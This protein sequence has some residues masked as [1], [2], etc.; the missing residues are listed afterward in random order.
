[1]GRPRQRVRASVR[2][3]EAGI[4]AP[5]RPRER[6]NC[7]RFHR[8]AG[9]DPFTRRGVHRDRPCMPAF[10]THAHDRIQNVPGSNPTRGAAMG[11]QA[12]RP[13]NPSG[14]HARQPT[15]RMA[16]RLFDLKHL[17]T[18]RCLESVDTSIECQPNKPTTRAPGDW[19]ASDNCGLN[20][21]RPERKRLATVN[22]CRASA[23]RRRR[24]TAECLP[25]NAPPRTTH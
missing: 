20:S 23:R 12:R 7:S 21:A 19:V 17:G 3:T 16:G 8:D 11:T 15:A 24:T 25:V 9:R 13:C 18:I 10:F 22:S 4:P 2:G 6:V 5:G 1:M 14:G